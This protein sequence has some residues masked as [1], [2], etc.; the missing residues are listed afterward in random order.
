MSFFCAPL[1]AFS[2]LTVLHSSSVTYTSARLQKDSTKP[3][4]GH[5]FKKQK[6]AV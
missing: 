2:D 3:C 1:W 5:G 4:D 6:E